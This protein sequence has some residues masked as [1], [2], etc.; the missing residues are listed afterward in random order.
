MVDRLLRLKIYLTILQEEGDLANNLTDLQWKIISDLKTLLQPFMIA[1][2]L[3]E[4]QTYVTISLVPY[5]IY[6]M[7]KDLTNAV[8][9]ELSSQHVVITGTRMLNKLNEIFGTGAPGTVAVDNFE[10]GA[11]RR[12][13][14]IPILTLMAS[15]LDP[16]MKAG[17]GI[18][19]LDKGYIWQAIK[20]EA[21][22][23]GMQ[24]N[25]QAQQVAEINVDEDAENIAPLRPNPNQQL[26]DDMFDEINNNYLQ[27]QQRMVNR[28]NAN[29][30]NNNNG[31]LQAARQESV[32]R[33]VISVD[34]ELLLYQQEPSLHLQDAQQILYCGGK[35]TKPST[36]YYQQWL[37]TYYA[38][39]PPQPLQKGF[40]Q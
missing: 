38:S 11:R 17:I 10:E 24:E 35:T 37:C 36:G 2:R 7:R 14:G 32:D 28:P 31:Q 4:G 25:Q 12:P 18:P 33:L 29:N 13:K 27:E 30:N 21:I 16:R 22:H 3:L 15:L 5:M 9:N 6:K 34:A 26:Y 23:I 40:F 19:D 1:Q 20:N 39:Q 8:S